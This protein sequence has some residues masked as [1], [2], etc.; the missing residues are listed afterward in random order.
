MVE[1]AGLAVSWAREKGGKE[2]EDAGGFIGAAG[3]DLGKHLRPL[4]GEISG[5][6]SSVTGKKSGQRK[7]KTG[8]L[9]GGAR[10]QRER[11]GRLYRFGNEF[12]WA[13][14]LFLFWAEW[15]PRSPF[16][17]FFSF[18]FFFCFLISFISFAF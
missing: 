8:G 5:G 16:R 4:K 10:C 9:T 1:F 7:K 6:G 3:V 15:V 2:E 17:I 11:R 12:K 13:A 14:G 18:L